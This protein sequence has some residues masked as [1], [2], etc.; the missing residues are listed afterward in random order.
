MTDEAPASPSEPAA[1]SPAP[2]AAPRGAQQKKHAAIELFVRG[3][4]KG[5]RSVSLYKEGHAMVA[6]ITT[7]VL[8]LLAAARGR[9]VS[10]SLDVKAKEAQ[11][12]G[13]PLPNTAEITEFASS[14]HTL[15]VGQITFSDRLQD[16]GMLEL[17]RLLVLKPDDAN[18][19]ELLQKKVQEAKIDGLQIVSKMSFVETEE[20]SQ[21]KPG[22][23][24]EEQLQAFCAAAS[25]PDFLTLLFKQNE[26]ISSKE[27][28][29]LTNLL[30]SAL[31]R[32]ISAEALREKL[33]WSCYDPRILARFDELLA[34]IRERRKWSGPA[35][36][37]ELSTF[38]N[39]DLAFLESGAEHRADA[40]FRLAV[41][42]VH[43]ILEN[44][45]GERQPKFALQAYARLLEDEGRAGA[46]ESLLAES[47]IWRKMAGDAKWGSYLAV[48]KHDVQE[49][50]P[51]AALSKALVAKLVAH[52]PESAA[53][54][55]LEDFTLS[56]G[57]KMTP[58]L[59]EDLR[60]VQD[61]DGRRR[62]A[63]L[64]ARVCRT[65]DV[66]PVLDAISDPDYFHVMQA[67]GILVEMGHP[68]AAE[69]AARLLEHEHPKV[70]QTSLQT[71]RRLGGEVAVEGI[72]AFIASGKHPEETKL[73]VT[74]LSLIP[75]KTV[76]DKL[77]A[78]YG[79]N[80]DYETRVAIATALG[81][82]PGEKV[83][84]FL[85][86]LAAWNW[87][88]WITGTNKDLRQAARTSLHQL[89]VEGFGGA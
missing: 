65:L 15:G 50:V 51:S 14:L 70:R 47:A 22:E 10:L 4:V 54:K 36:V 16:A 46:L 31:N 89:K 80:E 82:F 76:A 88:E 20:V 57:D 18:P 45:V 78:V 59:M 6:Q 27:G 84:E 71:L 38:S 86:P 23:L 79:R 44:P 41:D 32:E 75:G 62:L 49:R 25:I 64:L 56:L 1:S 67:L 39:E 24:S 60:G 17:M 5:A 77:I 42:Q 30:D 53:F 72:Y 66:K 85:Q 52:E 9:E 21:Q 37:C 58:L 26:P 87:W 2:S 40:A 3:L 28:A 68:N 63:A 19:L 69:C 55:E 7:R 74:T 34:D 43:A 73:A 61:K 83:V 33:P 81:R 8:A 35:L 11:L 29:A 13:E 12:D 48:L